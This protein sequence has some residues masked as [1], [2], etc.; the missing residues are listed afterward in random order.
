MTGEPDSNA[1]LAGCTGQGTPYR[2]SG[3]DVSLFLES[4]FSLYCKHFVDRSEKD[5]PDVSQTL[6]T[7]HGH[8]HE[9]RL[10]R[11][12]YPDEAPR[13]RTRGPQSP[14]GSRREAPRSRRPRR[15]LSPQEHAARLDK[16]RVAEFEKTLAAMREGAP[17]LLEPQLCYFPRGMHGSPDVLERRD[18]ESL[19]GR[20]HYV[21]KE[22]K[23]SKRIRRKHIMQAAF[24]NV[25][26][27]HIQGRLPEHFHL[28]NADGE[29]SEYEHAKYAGEIDDA[30]AGVVG[31]ME[32][33]MPPVWYGRGIFPWSDYSDKVAVQNDD[34]SLISGMDW[35]AKRMLE[36]GGI[37]TVAALLEAG[38]P[39]LK[40]SG[41]PS[42][43]AAGY[44]A[45]A[46]AIKSGNPVRRGPALAVRRAE[47]EVFLRIEEAMSGE[48]YM[49]GA[50]IRSGEDRR[51]HTFVSAG[52]DEEAGMLEGFLEVIQNLGR[53]ATYYWGSG[54]AVISRLAKK[55]RDEDMP[56][57]PMTDLQQLAASLVAFPTYRDK[58]KMVAEWMGFAWRD[59][60]AD[61]GRGVVAY[62]RYAADRDRSD[63]LA[64]IVRYA[65][66]NC[67]AVERVWDWLLEHD[68]VRLE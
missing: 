57:I 38:A 51:H 41:V 48:V 10:M 24:Y 22:I 63:C 50:L 34:L 59:P 44:V 20:H 55:H 26:L 25:M 16:S 4:P 3:S 42:A 49:I 33:K 40:K 36:E 30:L 66:D 28:L 45:R 2:I 67:A 19:L 61:W 46:R 43:D 58:L 7:E 31:V 18:G 9:T 37:G 5:P 53:C 29:D 39:T 60:D 27:G 32:G 64:Y 8:S 68:Y 17:T 14:A 15:W 54:E 12:M 23:S 52:P 21:V 47:A 6:F 65:E 62:R 13:P 11:E 35:N 56:D 1:V